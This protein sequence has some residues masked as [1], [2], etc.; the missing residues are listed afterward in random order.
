MGRTQAGYLVN[1]DSNA[2][3][4]LLSKVSATL[5]LNL[6][7]SRVSRG[8]LTIPT[9]VLL[10]LAKKKKRICLESPSIYHGERQELMSQVNKRLYFA[11]EDPDKEVQELVKWSLES[12]NQ[13]RVA[14]PN[15]FDDLSMYE[16]RNDFR[17]NTNGNFS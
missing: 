1:A 8:C 2:C 11:T 10:W 17:N 9:R 16:E 7:L 3:A 5:N 14:V 13:N 15:K 6:D 4:N 12:F